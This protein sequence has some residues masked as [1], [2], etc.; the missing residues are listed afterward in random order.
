MWFNNLI[1]FSYQ[2]ELSKDLDELQA[3]LEEYQL[4]P[5]PPHA[6][7]TMGFDAILSLAP[8]IL[9]HSNNACHMAALT[10]RQRLLP[11][12]VIKEALEEKK[13][14]YEAEHQRTMPRS[15]VLQAKETLEFDLLP[16]AFTIDK[17]RWFYIDTK[18]QWV[19]VN[20]AQPNQASDVIAYLIKAFGSLNYAPIQLDRALPELMQH[21]L[22]QPESLT[23]GFQLGKQCQLIR[24]EDDKTT[25]NCKDIA[26]H[27]QYLSELLE[28]GFIV[29]S[30]ELQWQEKLSFA[31]MD[32]FT[33]KR[34]KCLDLLS[35]DLKENQSLESQW[36]KLDADMAL[37]TGE[38]RA[39][40]TDFSALVEVEFES[41]SLETNATVETV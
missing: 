31:L 36:A 24:S 29:K 12:S 7:S 9:F 25:Y 23:N 16:K 37:L 13:Q 20:S 14:A 10:Q 3:Q 34:V 27:Y 21:W 8:E 2:N 4:K 32:N 1:F 30:L 18:K 19:V 38:L 17:K 41:H 22:L 33:F 28:Q 11:A 26:E 39:L 35:E 6:K 40:M 15:D 5:C